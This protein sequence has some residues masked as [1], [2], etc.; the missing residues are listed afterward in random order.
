MKSLFKTH[1]HCCSKKIIIFTENRYHNHGAYSCNDCIPKDCGF[2]NGVDEAFETD[3]IDKFKK[4]FK[5]RE[6]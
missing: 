2:R 4:I 6:R 1:C 5:R 3:I